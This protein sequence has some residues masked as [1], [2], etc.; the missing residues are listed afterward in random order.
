MSV[1]ALSMRSKLRRSA[2]R[3][4]ALRGLDIDNNT[5][6][7]LAILSM[8]ARSLRAGRVHQVTLSGGPKRS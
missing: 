7:F 5:A 1:A 8:D 2:F 4:Q 3:V 6:L